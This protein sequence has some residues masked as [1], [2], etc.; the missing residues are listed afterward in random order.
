MS[1]NMFL[2]LQLLSQEETV[3]AIEDTRKKLNEALAYFES[4]DLTKEQLPHFA[5]F[6]GLKLETLQQAHVFYTDGNVPEE[7]AHDSYGL[8]HGDYPTF[9][10][11]F[12]YPVF[13]VKGDVMGFC[14]YDVENAAKYLDS[15]NYGYVAKQYSCY[16]MEKIKE[17][18]SNN[19]LVLFTE[20]IVCTLAA[21]EE[22]VQSLALLGSQLSPFM[23]Q[24]VSWFGDRAVV[25]MDSDE[26]G[27]KFRKRIG[28]RFR[29]A[30]SKIAKDLDDSRKVNPNFF[31][32]VKKLKDPF[33]A[34]ELFR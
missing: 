19:E 6:R 22:G 30:Q 12:V 31:E 9:V 16:G 23:T 2:Q 3:S 13:D 18:M 25:F 14:G 8:M 4:T 34:S 20:G 33:Y 29:C 21:R 7:F 11:R 32:E 24:V 15:M 27:T 10:D 1:E 28:K 26:A 17:Y 5:E